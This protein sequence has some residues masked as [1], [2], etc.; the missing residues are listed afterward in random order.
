[1][2]YICFVDFKKVYDSISRKRHLLKLKEIELTGKDSKRFK[3]CT[4]LQNYLFDSRKES[5]IPSNQ[6]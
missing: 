3:R 1:M 6:Y 4:R 5:Q 2:L